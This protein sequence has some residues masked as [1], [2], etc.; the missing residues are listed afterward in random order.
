MFNDNRTNARFR[1][2]PNEIEKSYMWLA[3]SNTN[4]PANYVKCV[5]LF[6]FLSNRTGKSDET[7]GWATATYLYC[8][9]GC[10]R[11]K[12]ARLP[13]FSGISAAENLHILFF[14]VYL[15]RNSYI[16][17]ALSLWWYQNVCV[18]VDCHCVGTY[19]FAL[20]IHQI[21]KHRLEWDPEK[22]V[23]NTH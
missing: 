4:A 9:K 14:L 7:N 19:F 8:R 3:F 22:A 2:T 1:L 10:Y 13:G 15:D 16:G 17:M 23:N 20:I 18:C 21:A 6:G 11:W 5:R 12:W